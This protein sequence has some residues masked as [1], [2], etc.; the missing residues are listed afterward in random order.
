M[1]TPFEAH[2]DYLP[3]TPLDRIQMAVAEIVAALRDPEVTTDGEGAVNLLADAVNVRLLPVPFEMMRRIDRLGDLLADAIMGVGSRRPEL[4]PRL[5][6]GIEERY[7]ELVEV[8]HSWE[9]AALQELER[10]W[11]SS[12]AESA[13]Q[14]PATITPSSRPFCGR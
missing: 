14:R 11:G 7:C 6:H 2:D 1:P 4:R 5:R 10:A 8:V 9:A 13:A 12:T 3:V